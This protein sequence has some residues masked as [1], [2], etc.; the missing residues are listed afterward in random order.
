MYEKVNIT[1]NHLSVLSLFTRGFDKGYYIRE[2]HQILNISPRTAQLILADLEKKVILE[3]TTRGKVRIYT[4]KKS[5]LSIHYFTLVETYKL[6]TF[7]SQNLLMN[8][9]VAKITPHIQGIG[10]IFGS[11]AAGLENKDSDIDLFVIGR[12][13]EK[14]INAITQLYG[15]EISVKSYP[16]RIFEKNFKNDFLIKEVLKNHIVFSN[17]EQFVKLVFAHG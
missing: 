12:H 15:K 8:E 1:E 11:Y 17:A 7:L 9:L 3:S 6:I 14:N 2:V 4:I 13:N 16:L 5:P 10:I